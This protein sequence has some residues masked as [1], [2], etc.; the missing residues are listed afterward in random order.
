M[1]TTLKFFGF[2][3]AVVLLL[4]I[5]IK[6]KTVFT[7]IYGVISPGTKGAQKVTE[8][9]VDSAVVTTKKYS[10]KLFENSVPKVKSKMKNAKDAV[11]SNFSA[12]VRSEQE[13]LDD[14]K[15]ED[16]EE[17]DELIK[18]QNLK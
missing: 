4:S 18:T 17:L 3:L 13:P 9:L 7:H 2:F 1:K 8:N 6:D 5:T 14:I 12:P 15:E 16:K 11:S 10:K